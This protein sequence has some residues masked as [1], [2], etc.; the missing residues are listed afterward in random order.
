MLDKVIN[1]GKS[2]K[3]F[4]LGL[5]TIAT[6]VFAWVIQD[7]I[8]ALFVASILASLLYRIYQ[9]IANKLGGR[10]GWAAVI[11][12]M[13]SLILIVIPL[14]LF[15]GILAGQAIEIS[16]SAGDWLDAHPNQ[17]EILEQE[18]EERPE[19]KKLLPYQD[20]IINKTSQLAAKIS[21][22]A[23]AILAV[24]AKGTAEFGLNIFVMIIAMAYFLMNGHAL[25]IAILTH[26]PFTEDD[27][28]QLLQIFLSVGRATLKGTVTIG[29]I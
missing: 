13:T 27:K 29:V 28:H 20:Q 4:L 14:L 9:R 7:F 16:D 2:R 18:L 26:T 11:T 8:K 1:S 5:A 6:L 21:S 23:V 10:N 19:L 25:I 22:K 15:S 24:T 17:S 12:V 3:F